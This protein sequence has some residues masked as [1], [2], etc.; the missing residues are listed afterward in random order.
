M[1]GPRY[2]VPRR[3]NGKLPDGTKMSFT[4]VRDICRKQADLPSKELRLQLL[5]LEG[6]RR[7][8]RLGYYIIQ[9][10]EGPNKGKWVWGQFA[11]MMPIDDLLWLV[12]EARK[13][14]WPTP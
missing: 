8:V 5:E 7:E 6:G 2:D 3:G 12:D 13:D 4:I 10:K 14:G 11:A 9:K 1:E